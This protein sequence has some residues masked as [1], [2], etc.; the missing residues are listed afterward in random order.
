[1][2]ST[3][4]TRRCSQLAARR[5]RAE[6]VS[7]RVEE[8]EVLRR[9]RRSLGLGEDVSEGAGVA[10]GLHDAHRLPAGRRPRTFFAARDSV[11]GP[12]TRA[13][14]QKAAVSGGVNA[15]TRT[16]S[17]KH[18]LPLI[19]EPHPS[20]LGERLREMETGETLRIED[21][22]RAQAESLISLTWRNEA[23]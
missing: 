13:I 20:R 2:A 10:A 14:L 5:L 9:L 1:M 22:M 6:I 4:P 15:G 19:V 12:A 18:P 3:R 17:S 16:S 7:R 21:S 23:D 8:I 11:G